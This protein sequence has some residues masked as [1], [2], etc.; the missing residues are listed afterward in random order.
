MAFQLNGK[1][2]IVTGSSSGLGEAIAILF[3]ARGASVTLCG[4]DEE[5]LKSVYEK[6]VETSGGHP[7]RFI[8]VRGDLND[9]KVRENVVNQT[10]SKFGRLDILV[11]NAGISNANCSLSDATDES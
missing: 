5:R 1:V 3:A 8:T 11:A 4:R 6:A 10:V 9:Q 2:A 7:E